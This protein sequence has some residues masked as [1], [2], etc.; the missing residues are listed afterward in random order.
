MS[1]SVTSGAEKAQPLNTH[2]SLNCSS[3]VL[4]GTGLL[5]SEPRV[6]GVLGKYTTIG[7]FDS[8]G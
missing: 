8:L 4:V 5:G 1:E 6:L 2:P 3:G 7:L